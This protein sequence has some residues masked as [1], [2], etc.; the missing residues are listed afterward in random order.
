MSVPEDLVE[1]QGEWQSEIPSF[2][3]HS[4]LEMGKERPRKV[5]A[6]QARGSAAST[7]QLCDPERLSHPSVPQF[8]H[9]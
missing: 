4:F 5:T 8:L 9:L 2:S 7:D 1:G 6:H 3:T